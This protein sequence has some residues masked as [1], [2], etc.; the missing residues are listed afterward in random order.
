MYWIIVVI[1]NYT[2]YVCSA[3]AVSQYY[4]IKK[5]KNTHIICHVLGHNIGTIAWSIILLPALI[6][7]MIFGIF[8]FLLTSDNPNAV[9]RFLNK[10][11]TCCCACYERFFDMYSENSFTISYLG[12]IN[13]SPSNYTFYYLSERYSDMFYSLFILGSVFGLLGKAI[14]AIL[15][16]W[17]GYLIYLNDP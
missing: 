7:K 11:L 17:L 3:I 12:S 15:T 16:T 9:Q 5:I 10:A 1:N 4:R 2:D 14:V 13:F 8:D 6:V